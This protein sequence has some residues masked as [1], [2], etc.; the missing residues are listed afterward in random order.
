M[1]WKIKEEKVDPTIRG[2]EQYKATGTYFPQINHILQ[3]MCLWGDSVVVMKPVYYC[4]CISWFQINDTN[5]TENDNSV[6]VLWLI[7]NLP[8]NQKE[9]DLAAS[10][11]V[12][13]FPVWLFESV[14]IVVLWTYKADNTDL[15][16]PIK[17][18]FKYKLW[19]AKNHL[20]LSIILNI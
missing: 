15:L 11:T 19:F 10:N 4:T 16:L 12:V 3:S 5:T 14:F 2:V 9:T 17:L 20:K 1:S 18:I 7:I 8:C 6:L 13:V